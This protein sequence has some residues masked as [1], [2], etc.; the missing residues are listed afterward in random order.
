MWNESDEEDVIT[1]IEPPCI[2]DF[3]ARQDSTGVIVKWIVA[4]ISYMRAVHNLSDAAA[5]FVLKFFSILFGILAKI[6][7]PCSSIAKGLPSSLYKLQR[8]SGGLK[9]FCRYVVCRRC[10][11]VYPIEQCKERNNTSKLC[12]YIQFPDHRYARMRQ[13]CNT[14]LLKTVELSSGKRLLYPH[15]TYCYLSVHNS[16]Q[17]LLLRPSFLTDCEKW[18][19]RVVQHN[20]LHDVYD[21][22]MWSE[23]QVYNGCPFLS[24]PLS[25]AFT[26]NLDW[27]RPFKHSNFSVG[28][29]YMTIMNLPRNLRNKPEN[30]LLVGILPG[31]SEPTNINGFLKPLVDEL[32]EF[33]I[34]KELEIYG[35]S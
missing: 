32:K 24:D 31:P 30:I 18:R 33:W 16:L 21:G 1:D 11:S 23:F 9:Q 17:S 25:F 2:S 4:F 6:S 26:I 28:A 5:G 10:D 20:T 12:Q 14:L 27:F 34:G 8:L 7:V 22:K 13:P 19:K 29:M 35:C 3:T 15:L